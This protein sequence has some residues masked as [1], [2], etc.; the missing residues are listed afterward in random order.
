VR[1]PI[2]SLKPGQKVQ[3]ATVAELGAGN[4][5]LDMILYQKN[6]T[7]FL[8]MSNNS[9]GVMK[10]RAGD[11]AGASPITGPVTTPTGGVGYETIA[12]MQ[13][14]EQLDQLDAQN[15]IVIAR[16]NGGLNLQVVPLP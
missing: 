4:R 7:D 11:V 3:G 16:V 2:D 1:F 12:A 8:L 6:G 9:R 13:G 14:I 15:S 10:I 5:P